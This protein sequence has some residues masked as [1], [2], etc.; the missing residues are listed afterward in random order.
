MSAPGAE[1]EGG[2]G[3]NAP[4]TSEPA[5]GRVWQACLACRRKKVRGEHEHA[6][7]IPGTKADHRSNVMENNPVTIAVLETRL[8]TFPEPKTMR[9]QADSK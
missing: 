9:Q 8:A 7:M 2:A 3:P 6:E 5:G 4:L 1:D